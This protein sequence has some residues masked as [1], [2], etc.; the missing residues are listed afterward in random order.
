MRTIIIVIYLM[1]CHVSSIP[2]WFVGWIIGKINPDMKPRYAQTLIR[3]AFKDILFIAGVK[4]AVKGQENVLQGA[5]A[6]Y[7]FNHR[8]YF[9]ILVGY[10]T[11]P[12]PM[13]FVSKD[14]LAHVPLITRWMKAMKCLFLDRN[15]LKKGASDDTGRN[16]AFEIRTFC[17]Y[18]SGGNEKEIHGD[19][20]QEFHQASFKLAEKSHRPIIPVALN[21]PDEAFEN[22][23]PW[24]HSTHVIVEYCKP[25]YMD[26]VEKL[27]EH[28][29]E[30]VHGSYRRKG[31]EKSGRSL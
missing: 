7:V 6:M 21:N 29:A 24:I 9:D 16:R 20:L 4:V 2:A 22:H 12:M 11:G 3:R 10:T 15:D 26:D 18:C 25:I 28:V 13:A 27:E 5:S 23:F 30:K 31:Q 17:I 1:L 8:S 19:E 14:D